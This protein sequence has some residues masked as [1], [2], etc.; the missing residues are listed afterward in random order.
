MPD[1]H[2]NLPL[3]EW[4]VLSLRPSGQHA[5]AHCASK[6]RG[7]KFLSCSSIKLKTIEN[8]ADLKKALTCNRLIVTSPAAARFAAK[9]PVFYIPEKSS[10]YAIGQ[11]TASILKKNGVSEIITSADGADSESLLAL[12]GLQD[13]RGKHIGLLTA[14]GGRGLIEPELVKRGAM[15][16]TAHVYQ[17]RTIAITPKK[18]RRLS[19]LNQPFAVL[20]SSYEVFESFWQ[21]IPAATQEIMKR[22]L[23]I[24]S[25]SRLEGLIRK[26]GIANTTVSNSAQPGVM[27]EH[28]VHVQTQQ[29]R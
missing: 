3:R 15:V 14:P 5:V 6:V 24:A 4:T 26:T 2:L 9:S 27:L 17:R 19:T 18:L 1:R 29:V 20:C 16:S 25:S 8:D 21:Q 11:G 13:I 23:W 12:P 28:L 22:G 7:A 10:W